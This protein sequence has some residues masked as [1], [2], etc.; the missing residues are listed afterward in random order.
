MSKP[1]RVR[2]IAALLLALL[3]LLVAGHSGH[4]HGV[5][6]ALPPAPATSP[7]PAV[8][9]AAAGASADVVSLPARV[10]ADPRRTL[11]IAAP[12]AGAVIAPKR[13]FPAAGQWLRA[14]ESLA[15]LQPALATSARRDIE[16]QL[17]D[18]RRDADI[19]YLQIDR[20]GIEAQKFDV[21]L[22]TQTLQIVTDYRAAQVRRDQM[23][24]SLSGRLAITAP[25]A[26]R[27]LRL[28]AASGRQ[29]A[30]GEPLF[31][32]QLDDGLAVEA[33]FIDA[34]LVVPEVAIARL[35]DGSERSLHLLGRGYDAGQRV[36]VVRYALAGEAGAPLAV[37]QRLSLRLP[38]PSG[39]RP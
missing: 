23:Q 10:I 38:Q 20:Y 31:V 28:D 8:A 22:P 2:G 5:V 39:S 35:E 30:A 19:G 25:R 26:G 12:Q 15:E 29:Y 36:S 27:L 24:E 11:V 14:G 7:A 16:A 13:G 18:A 37:N 6:E 32:V 9:A 21:S 33:R 3:P 4:E 34:D 17:V 1:G